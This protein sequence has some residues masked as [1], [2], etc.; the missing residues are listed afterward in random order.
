MQISSSSEKTS[1]LTEDKVAT[2]CD[3]PDARLPHARRGRRSESQSL[4]GSRMKI[5]AV[6]QKAG[7]LKP[8]PAAPQ[9]M[10]SRPLQKGGTSRG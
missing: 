3:R 5:F 10:Q 9:S 7:A 4:H 2:H 6:F 8:G 1:L